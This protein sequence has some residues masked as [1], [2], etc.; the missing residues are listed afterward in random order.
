[1]EEKQSDLGKLVAYAWNNE[2]TL[3]LSEKE[4]AKESASERVGAG[5]GSGHAF[6]RLVGAE[7]TCHVCGGR[8]GPSAG[9]LEGT[10]CVIHAA[11]WGSTEVG[12]CALRLLGDFYPSRPA[13]SFSPPIASSAPASHP[14][15]VAPELRARQYV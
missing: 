14:A 8:R 11:Q 9:L 6:P 13:P 1:M 2:A 10:C 7:A 12:P 4:N 5:N 3:T 15:S